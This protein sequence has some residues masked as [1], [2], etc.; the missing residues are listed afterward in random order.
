MT[1]KS[2]NAL[3]DLI[4]LEKDAIRFGFEW[5]N[6]NMILEQAI[7]EC[8]EI[9]EALEKNEK[10]ERIQEEIGDLLHSAISLCVFAG[11]DIEETLE[12]VNAKFA[13]RMQAMKLL[14]HE[15]GLSNLQGKSID[16]MM[17]LWCKAKK[18]TEKQ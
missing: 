4:D 7:D 8:R 2:G 14:T 6:E 13:K 3:N 5:P 17:E 12:K 18:V 11:F 10:S 9:K 15:I 1:K 16:F